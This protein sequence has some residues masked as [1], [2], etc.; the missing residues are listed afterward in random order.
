M[1]PSTDRL[2]LPHGLSIRPSTS[3][4]KEF[5]RNLYY[6]TRHD[7]KLIEANHD[8]IGTLIE[9]QYEAQSVGYGD[10]FPNALYFIIEKQGQSIGRAIL[11]FAQ[12]AIHVIDITLIPEARGKGFGEGVLKA[13]Q[14]A[15]GKSYAPLRLSVYSGNWVAK[16]LYIK[17]GFQVEQYHPPYERMVWYPTIQQMSA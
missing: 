6:S 17:L 12:D 1:R 16:Q 14:Y 15:A 2:H 8:F 11:D 4:D 7:L 5:I 10:M 13:L 9:Q 3:S